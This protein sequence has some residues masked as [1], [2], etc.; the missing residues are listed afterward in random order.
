MPPGPLYHQIPPGG[1]IGIEIDLHKK[2]IPHPLAARLGVFQEKAG[3]PL[4]KNSFVSSFFL[5]P[6]PAVYAISFPPIP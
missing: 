4:E 5:L 3:E 6:P 2:S 1:A